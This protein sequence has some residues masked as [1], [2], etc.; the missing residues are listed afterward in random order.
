MAPDAAEGSP[1]HLPVASL[2]HVDSMLFSPVKTL[3]GACGLS[4]LQNACH[5][6]ENLFR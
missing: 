6:A 2:L 5:A 3:P 1:P 4:C